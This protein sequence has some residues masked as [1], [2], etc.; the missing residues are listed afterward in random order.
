MWIMYRAEEDGKGLGE[1]RGLTE[2]GATIKRS[3]VPVVII[4]PLARQQ[5][6]LVLGPCK[7]RRE[8]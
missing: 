2:T 1:I 6:F 3:L 4:I 8:K 7:T 5:V